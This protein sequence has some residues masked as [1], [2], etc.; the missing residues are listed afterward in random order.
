MIHWQARKNSWS[1]ISIVVI[2]NAARDVQLSSQ[3]ATWY[4]PKNLIF[5][6]CGQSVILLEK[7]KKEL[8]E[9]PSMYA[10]GISFASSLSQQIDYR[11]YDFVPIWSGIMHPCRQTPL[12]PSLSYHFTLA[13]SITHVK[14]AANASAF[15]IGHSTSP[16]PP[17]FSFFA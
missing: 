7:L 4:D 12:P 5:S 10:T 15:S 6:L 16:I 3:N 11:L 13:N 14:A 17:Q 8:T 9:P 1:I 2:W